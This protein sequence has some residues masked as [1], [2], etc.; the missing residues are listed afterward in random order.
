MWTILPDVRK[1]A[2]EVA[3]AMGS[4]GPL[5]VQARKVRGTA[6]ASR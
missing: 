2:E 5:N 4:V 6:V 1:A 3:K